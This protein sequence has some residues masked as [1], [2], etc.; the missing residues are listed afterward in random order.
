MT[1][2]SAFYRLRWTWD[3]WMLQLR[4][5]MLLEYSQFLSYY[6]CGAALALGK[7]YY[8]WLAQR[9]K[10]QKEKYEGLRQGLRKAVI[11][12]LV[13]TTFFSTLW[14]F[15]T[16]DQ[17]VLSVHIFTDDSHRM[18]DF[19]S[20]DSEHNYP[21]GRV[22]WKSCIWTGIKKLSVEMSVFRFLLVQLFHLFCSLVDMAWQIHMGLLAGVGAYITVAVMM[23]SNRVE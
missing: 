20:V 13:T 15:Y 18:I 16:A 23:P 8:Y 7:I 4:I 17:D 19:K 14:R 9:I 11:Y 3:G 21:G 6:Y 10:G 1:F 2:Y 5:R 12:G 22:S